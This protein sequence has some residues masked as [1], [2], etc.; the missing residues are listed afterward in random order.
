MHSDSMAFLTVAVSDH[1]NA[2][3]DGVMVKLPVLCKPERCLLH[4]TIHLLRD[5]GDKS[6]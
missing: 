1:F 2:S 4:P 3:L 6:N 5:G